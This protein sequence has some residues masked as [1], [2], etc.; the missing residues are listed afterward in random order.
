MFAV[1]GFPS[2]GTSPQEY[3]TT[4]STFLL[5]SEMEPIFNYYAISVLRCL[6]NHPTFR[7]VFEEKCVPFHEEQWLLMLISGS[8]QQD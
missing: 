6:F 5:G 2:T 3:I 4:T 7:D 8:V 1:E